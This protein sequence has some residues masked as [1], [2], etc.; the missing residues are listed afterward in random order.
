MEYDFQGYFDSGRRPSDGA[1]AARWD[2]GLE[3]D[4]Q[5]QLGPILYWGLGGD[6]SLA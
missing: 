3:D 5:V 2:E 4:L 6:S 1:G